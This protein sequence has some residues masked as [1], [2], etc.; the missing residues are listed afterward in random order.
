MLGGVVCLLERV[1]YLLERVDYLM[2]RVDCLPALWLLLFFRRS[3][4]A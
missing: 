1:D 2:E 3:S 4:K